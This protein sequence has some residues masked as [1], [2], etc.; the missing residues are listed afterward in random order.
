M[1]VSSVAAWRQD[2]ELASQHGMAIARF[3]RET[4]ERTAIVSAHGERSFGELNGRANRLARALRRS[5]LRRDDAV[6]LMCSNRAEFVEVYLAC[7]R[8]GL[9][10]T[11]VNWHL[12]AAE[13]G[14]IVRDCGARAL[15]TAA[16]FASLVEEMS[17]DL[18][19]VSLRL[20]IGGAIEG[21][22]SY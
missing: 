6:A 7:L 21:F 18:A 10:L 1:G 11:S 8:S 9:R 5:G 22:D 4:P 19:E 2:Q 16:R 15:V 3:A 14:Y 12:T 20:S 13:A 17:P